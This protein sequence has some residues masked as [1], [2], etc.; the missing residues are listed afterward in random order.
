MV[1]LST[2]A[3]G[4]CY[5]RSLTTQNATVVLDNG[6]TDKFTISLLNDAEK[7][8][9]TVRRDLITPRDFHR[10]GGH[11]ANIIRGWDGM[12][13]YDFALPVDCD[14]R[15]AVFTEKG[16]SRS[17]E[18]IHN[19]FNALKGRQCAFRIDTSLFNVPGRDGWYAPVRHFH[20]GFVPAKTISHCDD[21][22]H[23]PR[24]ILSDEIAS[25][26]FTYLHDH[27]HPYAEWRKRIKNKVAGLVD[28]NDE[29][30]IREYIKIPRAE[31]AHAVAS[32]LITK[33][34]YYKLYEKEIIIMPACGSSDSVIIEGPRIN[35]TIWDSEHYLK[36]NPDVKAYTTGTLQHYLRHGFHEGRKIGL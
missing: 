1:R 27:H 16:L 18:A 10:K 25:T 36:N 30:A 7:K 14:E 34:E 8:G 29:A 22:Q 28:P 20:K 21:G 6:S 11:L 26:H 23:E 5:P 2:N 12:Y 24:S 32:L 33:K 15:L 4:Q 35:A 31:G 3:S 13:D 17:K 9:C 19:A